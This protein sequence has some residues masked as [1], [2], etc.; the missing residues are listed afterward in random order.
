MLLAQQ[1]AR[2]Q[3]HQRWV[4]A[5]LHA[6]LGNRLGP[7]GAA[8][9]LP[10]VLSL[11]DPEIRVQRE[12]VPPSNYSRWHGA[13]CISFE[14]KHPSSACRKLG[15]GREHGSVWASITRSL[16]PHASSSPHRI[17]G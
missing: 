1:A 5:R 12:A 3:A 13:R 4:H 8:A 17:T 11:D 2:S 6:Q 16:C 14:R 9:H 15:R 7:V 10:L